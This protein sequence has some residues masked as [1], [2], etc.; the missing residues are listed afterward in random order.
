M[1][2]S[3]YRTPDFGL[4]AIPLLVSIVKSEGL[5]VQIIVVI[6]FNVDPR[7][8]MGENGWSQKWSGI[9]NAIL[10]LTRESAVTL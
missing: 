8:E 1:C 7:W 10:H 4:L 2:L 3:L 6:R 5:Q 9:S